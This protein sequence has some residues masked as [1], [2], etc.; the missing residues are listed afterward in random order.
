[1]TAVTIRL[2]GQ[3]L[4]VGGLVGA[5]NTT[6]KP[7]W[8]K[9]TK[10]PSSGV[11]TIAVPTKYTR[12]LAF[13][14]NCARWPNID[15][16]PIIGLQLKGVAAGGSAP[17]AS[18]GKPLATSGSY[19]WAGTTAATVSLTVTGWIDA[20]DGSPLSG[21]IDLWADPALPTVVSTQSGARWA[22]LP[23]GHQD[24]PYC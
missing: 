12:H 24:E 9:G 13:D 14:V 4:C 6:T 17:T 21:T 2:T 20:G 22:P 3:A 7:L 11:V 1:V 15:A 16:V 10:V 23:L 19:C 18:N 5:H 8:E